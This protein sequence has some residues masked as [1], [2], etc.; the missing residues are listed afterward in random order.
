MPLYKCTAI[1]QLTTA[2]STPTAPL[3]RQGGWSES[4]YVT[5]NNVAAAIQAF[6]QGSGSF[7]QLRASLLPLGSSIVGERYQQVNPV[8]PSQSNNNVYPS[9]L[10]LE[11]DQPQN[12]LLMKI[13]GVGVNNI[14]RMVL[15]AL[16]DACLTEG[17]FT[18]PTAYIN[19][20]VQFIAALSQYQFQGRDLSQAK[21]PLLSGTA[22]G[23]FTAINA[24][25]VAIGQFV[26]I[27]KARE[28]TTGNLRGGRFQV[29]AVTQNPN[30]LTVAMWPF[31]A[32]TGGNFRLDGQVFPQFG[33]LSGPVGRPIIKKVG[34]PST[35]YRGRRSRRR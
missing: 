16:P 31:G 5:A 7:C 23:V 32:T 1:F 4:I 27:L 22:A 13:P 28:T 18:P 30:T 10:G 3:H 12:A 24:P 25:V 9:T 15:R 20:L 34:R 26:R 8:G 29:T 21:Q 2:V 6:E 33:P 17:E 19:Q 35:G 14:R 11:A